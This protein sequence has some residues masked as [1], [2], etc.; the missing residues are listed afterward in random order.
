MPCLITY[1]SCALS[2]PASLSITARLSIACDFYFSIFSS[3]AAGIFL[4][5]EEGRPDIKHRWPASIQDTL[6]KCFSKPDERPTMKIIFEVIRSELCL[7]R[8]GD[9][10]KLRDSF[11]LRRRSLASAR[12]L[13]QVEHARRSPIN[14]GESVRATLA[15]SIT[16]FGRQSSSNGELGRI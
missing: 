7:L 10:A 9:T 16:N 12:N 4:V 8:N 3:F 13:V 6:K 5:I 2:C 1:V 14:I 15:S 11:L